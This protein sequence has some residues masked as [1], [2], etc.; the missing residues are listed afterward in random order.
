MRSVAAAAD[1]ASS[2]DVFRG[3]ATR[4]LCDFFCEERHIL[5]SKLLHASLFLPS[6]FSGILTHTKQVIERDEHQVPHS[7]L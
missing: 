2:S 4:L 1:M 5:G 3:S 7:V 6:C